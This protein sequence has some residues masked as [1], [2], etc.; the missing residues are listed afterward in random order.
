[1]THGI[2]AVCTILQCTVQCTC[3]VQLI[4]VSTVLYVQY[5]ILKKRLVSA[6]VSGKRNILHTVLCTL[7]KGL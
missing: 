4:N 2:S 7:I 5:S 1:M 3:R 6:K